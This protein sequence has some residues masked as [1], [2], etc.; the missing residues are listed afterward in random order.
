MQFAI[1]RSAARLDVGD[2]KKMAVGAARKAGAD[3]FPH[4]RTRAI[5]AR[6]VA[7]LA[8][9]LLAVRSAQP[10]QHAV[11]AIGES[12]Q[13]GSP[14]DCDAERVEPLDQQPLM[15]VLR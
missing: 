12:D 7:C 8:I 10:R 14:L 15:L 3:R 6:D 1:E 13:L 11:L 2:I 9:V 4:G 5:A